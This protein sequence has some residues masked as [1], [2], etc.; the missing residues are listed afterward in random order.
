MSL[1]ALP[2]GRSEANRMGMS[3]PIFMGVLWASREMPDRLGQ[4]LDLGRGLLD[5]AVIVHELHDLWLHGFRVWAQAA[6]RKVDAVVERRGA[7]VSSAPGHD[8]LLITK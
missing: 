2:G 5:A 6:R 1:S 4:R 7:G 3:A 8:A